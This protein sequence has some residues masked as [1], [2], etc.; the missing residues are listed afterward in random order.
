M[1]IHQ[2]GRRAP[3][4]QQAMQRLQPTLLPAPTRGICLHE[5]EAFMQPGGAIVQ[6]N[7]VSTM[8][9]VKL[10]G[11][12]IRHCDLHALDE[13]VPPV[14]SPL[15]LP[16][17]SS[18]EYNSG[19]NQ[20]MFAAQQTKLFDVTFGGPIL[21]KAGQTSGNY[22]ASQL[23]NA[24]G[25]YLIAVNDAGDAPLRYNGAAWET[26]DAG[27]ITGPL[28]S[29]VEAGGN[30]VYVWKY[31][32]R[33]FFIEG[34]SMNVWYLPLNA[35]QGALSLVPLSGAATKGGRLLFGTTWSLDAGDG[36]DDKMVVATTEGEL[37]VFTGSNP[38]DPA[39]WRQEGRFEISAPLGMNAHH[40]T[41]GD[42]LI[43]TVDGLV[44]VSGAITKDKI[45]LEL[46][47]ISRP[48]KPMW[49][50][51]VME[52]RE[53]PW[54]MEKW[55]EYGGMFVTWPYGVAGKR[56]CA[57]IN[58][59]TGAWARFVGWDATCWIKLRG[60]LYFGT[61]SG[62]VMAADRTGYDDGN[63]AKI[64]YVATLVGGWGAL[65]SQPATTTW[66]QARASFSATGREPFKPQLSAAT[67]FVLKLP[68]PPQAGAD[69]GLQE[70]WDQGLW[71]DARW[72]Q[73]TAVAAPAVRSTGWVSIGKSGFVHAPIVQVT[74]AQQVK[75]SVELIAIAATFEPG[76]INV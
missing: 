63:H 54:T 41:G 24:S 76:G 55:D 44:P 32:N 70:V 57:V 37:L 46:A 69:P 27:E 72:D 17:I 66:L 40:P 52:K 38:A 15:R 12:Y 26:L 3:V 2:Y 1:S 61:Q 28:G 33:L 16:V 34:G 75:P 6:D 65:R 62:I 50:A 9:G 4:P 58:L 74:V 19:N 60:E 21:V 29:T 67:D 47:A 5:N 71:D 20:H 30:L 23:A 10:R 8:R 48:I 51:E 36:V 68:P 7:W 59:A 18:F 14:P 13:P 45:Q 64:P 42:L 43:A 39:N 22:A 56:L 49:R 53:H 25:D 35:V 31:R 11:G 73:P